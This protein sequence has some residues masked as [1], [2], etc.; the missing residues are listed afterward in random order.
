MFT[1]CHQM[2][3]SVANLSRQGCVSICHLSAML[4]AMLS[5]QLPG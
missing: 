5:M 4:H 2:P 3:L 1:G